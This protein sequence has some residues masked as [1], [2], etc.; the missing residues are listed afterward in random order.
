MSGRTNTITLEE[1]DP[2]V[3]GIFLTWLSVGSIE[4][5]EDLVE[6]V[7][8][9]EKK[10]NTHKF[11][12]EFRHRLYDQLVEC[13]ILAEDLQCKNF[14]NHVMDKII[15]VVKESVAETPSA[16]L[17]GTLTSQ[18]IRV[19]KGTVGGSPLQLFLLRLFM[20]FTD[21]EK[22]LKQATAKPL[23][24]PELGFMQELLYLSIKYSDKFS[25]EGRDEFEWSQTR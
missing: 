11:R 17:V 20:V 13:Y 15:S 6:I 24:D 5:A 10:P 19:F 2:K 18:V 7:E 22:W 9:D 14:Q 12:H 8:L 23:H 1:G 21:V 25:A 16:L 3:F 4:N